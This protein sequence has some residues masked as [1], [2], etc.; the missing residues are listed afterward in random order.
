[1]SNESMK[2]VAPGQHWASRDKTATSAKGWPGEVVVTKT[3]MCTNDL[4]DTVV[5]EQGDSF[6]LSFPIEA[7]VLVEAYELRYDPNGS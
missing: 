1:M 2:E 3:K 4:I 5:T 6:G 7:H